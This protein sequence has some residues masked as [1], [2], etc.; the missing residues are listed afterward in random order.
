MK[1]VYLFLTCILLLGCGSKD[2]VSLE[3]ESGT[4]EEIENSEGGN[5][6]EEG[7]G[8][9]TEG[10]EMDFL[11]VE[12]LLS[13]SLQ[14]EGD[15]Y[16]AE[17]RENNT[18]EICLPFTAKGVAL[19]G[20][21]MLD[22]GVTI[23][24]DPGE[25]FEYGAE[26]VFVLSKEGYKDTEVV[27]RCLYLE[28]ASKY[29]T[30]FFLGDPEYDMRGFTKEQVQGMVSDMLALKDN[31]TL[32]FEP[33]LGVKVNYEPALV[34]ILGDIDKDR[35]SDTGNGFV[36]V[37]GEIYERGIPCVTLYGNHDWEPFHWGGLEAWDGTDYGFS[38]D[39]RK[40]NNASLDV[41][42]RSLE[43]SEKLGVMEVKK[44]MASDYG[45]FGYSEVMPFSFKF[46]TIRFYCGQ[47]FWFQQWYKAKLLPSSQATFYCTDEIV[48]DLEKNIDAG[49]GKEP[50]VWCQH[51]PISNQSDWWHDRQGFVMNPGCDKSRWKGY[52]A[53]VGKMKELIGKTKNPVFF[54]GHTHAQQH[55]EHQVPAFHEYVCGYFHDRHIYVALF[56]E[57]E[58]LV[59]VRSVLF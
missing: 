16:F 47:I 6:G 23:T 40:A 50:A 52:D 11:P 19:S 29:F 12:S 55:Y 33:S 10:K 37:F 36:E 7:G 20:I 13:F 35:S 27:V 3:E 56:K 49:W 57:G 15:F 54:A 5:T 1:I 34:M 51:Y 4:N 43:E 14:H 31:K 41:V 30:V 42:S 9:E 8:D 25:L 2:S 32:F 17:M 53:K 26:R 38:Y 44:F 21:C 48:D 58:G 22:S 28:D 45:H 18:F 24:P 59:D 39:G 46:R